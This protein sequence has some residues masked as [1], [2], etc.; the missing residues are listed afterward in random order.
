MAT[1]TDNTWE[2][3]IKNWGGL[4]PSYYSNSWSFRGNVGDAND[5]QDVDISDPNILTQGGGTA[6]LTNHASVTTTISGI[7]KAVTASN[8]GWA[9]GENKIYKLTSTSVVADA[10]FPLTLDKA[11]VTGETITDGA[12]YKSNL[13]FAYN[14]SGGVGDIAKMTTAGSITPAWGSTTPTGYG[15]LMSAPHYFCATGNDKLYVTNGNYIGSY[16]GTTYNT[17]A[18]DFYTDAQCNSIVWSGNRL[19]IAVNRPNITGSNFNQSAVYNWDGSA[20]SWDGDPIEVNGEIGALYVKNGVPYIWWKDGTGVGGYNFGYIN[21]T[22]VSVIKRY[23]GGLPNQNQVGEYY[24]YIIWLVGNE[25]MMWG[26]GDPELTV[27]LFKYLTSVYTTAG[28]LGSPFGEILISSSGTVEAVPV[29]TLEKESGYSVDAEYETIAFD[30]SSKDKKALVNKIK[31]T[32]ETIGAGGK[33]DITM[34]SD[35]NTATTALAQ[36]VAGSRRHNILTAGVPVNNIKFLIKWIN[37]SITNPV[38]I[39]EIF[40]SGTY[41]SDF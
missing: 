12:Y 22:Q 28:A 4:A 7:M 13:Y 41:I 33:C 15:A 2:F 19:I 36:I 29:Y 18:L 24:G 8:V 14:H 37:G 34:Y 32:T 38:K 16:D 1:Q 11:T 6:E 35:D 23:D 30:L 39:K 21:G 10:T 26:S 9:F 17:M 40:V 20:S 25:V 5:L 31:V 3:T 27:K